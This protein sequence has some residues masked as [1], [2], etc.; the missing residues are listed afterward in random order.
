M[1]YDIFNGSI[2]ILNIDAL[3]AL[4]YREY[5]WFVAKMFSTFFS[6]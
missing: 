1:V 3:L 6:V 5:S 4:V 2:S